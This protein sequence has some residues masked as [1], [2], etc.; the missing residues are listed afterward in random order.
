MAEKTEKPTDKKIKDSAKKGQ[1]YKSKD[2]VAAIVLIVSAFVFDGITNLNDLVILTKKILIS[3]ANIHID[4]LLWE[5]FTVF[6]RVLLPVLLACFLAGTLVSLLQSRFRLATEAVKIDFTKLNPIAGFKKIFS[7]NSLKELVKAFLYLIVFAISA[8]VFFYFWR[9]E[10]F[11]LYRTVLDG[12][13]QQWVSLSTTFIVVFLAVALLIIVI[14]M[15]TEFFLFIKNLKME[16]QEVKKEHKDNEGDPHI[17]SARRSIHQELLSEEVKSN[18]RNSTF[19]MANPTHIALLIYYDPDIA[20]LPFL[21]SKSRG[22]Q[23][24]AIIKYA[25]KQGVPV[26]RDI[27]LARK[28][29]RNYKKDRFIDE[30]GLE[31]IMN[32]VSWLIR[33]ELI[34]MGVDIDNLLEDENDK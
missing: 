5:F 33:V 12:M 3:P 32:I 27:P 34:R 8:G 28:I 20:P 2:S 22:L 25:E 13:I 30:T 11:M 31:E 23:A 21:F 9:H 4:T 29:W 17:K 16:K 26:V 1:S 18:V 6:I 15:I 19:V 7:L 14:D 10:I 24:K